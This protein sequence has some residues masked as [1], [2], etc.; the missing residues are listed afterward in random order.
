LQRRQI[1]AL[2]GQATQAGARLRLYPETKKPI[3]W[4]GFFAR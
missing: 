4:V 3:A 2:V 1:I